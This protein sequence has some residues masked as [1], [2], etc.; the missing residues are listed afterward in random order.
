M[1]NTPL[2]FED[3]DFTLPVDLGSYDF[4]EERV[5]DY[6][7]QFDPQAFHLDKAYAE[8]T[9]LGG[10]AASGWH[11]CAAL[12]KQLTMRFLINVQS[13]GGPGVKHLYWRKP[14]LAGD[15]LH[16][17]MTADPAS[18]RISRSRPEFGICDYSCT[19]INQ[20]GE[21]AYQ[22]QW[23]GF[24][25]TRTPP[26]LPPREAPREI[27]DMHHAIASVDTPGGY[28]YE[29]LA[30]GYTV[31]TGEHSISAEEII[32]FAREYDMQPFHLDAEVGR[33]SHFL[34]LAAS[35]WHTGAL[36][37]RAWVDSFKARL[38]SLSD[39]DQQRLLDASGPS[40]GF[41]DLRWLR[42]VL[43]GDTLHF[44]STP[45]KKTGLL[46]RG[47]WGVFIA[48]N[49]VLNQRKELVMQYFSRVIQKTKSSE[50]V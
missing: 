20:R 10:L 37:M 29:D 38:A 43:A 6:A 22:A 3:I 4:T 19:G 34:G 15:V 28:Y 9:I 33:K 31:K 41:D 48:R 18:A 40:S 45:I 21:I 1:Q 24:V 13:V 44:Y 11:V 46:K 17:T 47:G 14:V 16:F 8:T 49:D 39:A 30:L 25:A 26:P 35:G 27:V 2:Y 36:A 23:S 50:S 42:P 32:C 5:L 7:R 12:Q